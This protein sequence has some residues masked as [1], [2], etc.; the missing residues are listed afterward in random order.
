M[1]QIGKTNRLTVT[2][3]MPFAYVLA[4][5]EDDQEVMLPTVCTPQKLKEGDEVTVFV[6]PDENG[7]LSANT[8]IPKVCVGDIALLTTRGVTEFGAFFDWGLE[9]DLLVL[10][11]DQERPIA[12]GM[13]YL[14]YV[15]YDDKS[16]RV[17]G[18][19]RLHYFYPEKLR[20]QDKFTP[21]QAVSA[22][23]YAKTDLG[24]KVLINNTFLGLLFHSDAVKK[25]H[26]GD[27]I[28]AFIKQIRSDG[29]VDITMLSDSKQGR[30][31]LE[32]QIL[33]ELKNFGGLLT[34]TDKSSPEE[35]YALF[36]VSKGAYKKVIGKLYKEKRILL[37]KDSIKLVE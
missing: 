6:A 26:T 20:E 5:Q 37:S 27:T 18:S 33:D 25:L 4:H 15:Y 36:G 8:Q 22:I 17:L 19:T 31:S 24:Y 9:R 12:E 23:V 3:I 1:I 29:K 28:N 35:I 16:Q 21:Q 2:D 32:Q 30:I 11:K 14:V 13:Q 7:Q 34:V 10:K